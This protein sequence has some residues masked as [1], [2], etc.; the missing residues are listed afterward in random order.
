MNITAT[1]R[2]ARHYQR[3]HATLEAVK[4]SLLHIAFN[5]EL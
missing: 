1:L 5:G 4:K 2:K 3:K